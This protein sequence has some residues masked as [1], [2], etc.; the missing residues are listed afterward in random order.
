MNANVAHIGA[1]AVFASASQVKQALEVNVDW[2][3]YDGQRVTGSAPGK[4][5]L[6][7]HGQ[8]QW[9]PNGNTFNNLF[10]N[11]DGIVVSDYLVDSMPEGVPLSNGAL[12]AKGEGD[13]VFLVTNEKKVHIPNPAVF[14]KFNFNADT[15]VVVPQLLIDYIPTGPDVG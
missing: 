1:D 3:K 5:Y 7:L 14:E 9:I 12:L 13:K 2:T 11:W 6:A 10:K 15:I 4:V 8:L